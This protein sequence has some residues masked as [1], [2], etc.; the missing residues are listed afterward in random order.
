MI[1]HNFILNFDG[2]NSSARDD[3]RSDAEIDSYIKD[4]RI[5]ISA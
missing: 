5:D 4:I 3:C 1:T 2:C